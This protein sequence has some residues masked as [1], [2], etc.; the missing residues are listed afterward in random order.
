[1]ITMSDFYCNI[2]KVNDLEIEY[3]NAIETL[4]DYY[5]QLNNVV[6]CVESGQYWQGETFDEFKKKFEAWKEH[7]ISTLNQLILLDSSLSAIYSVS[8]NLIKSRN[9]LEQYLEYQ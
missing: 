4:T 2:D 9:D 5:Y 1:M 3:H 7:Y 6:N 8:L